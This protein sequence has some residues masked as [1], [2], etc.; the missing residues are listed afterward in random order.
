MLSIF[1]H[2]Y[3]FFGKKMSIQVFC[4]FFKHTILNVYNVN[5]LFFTK[6]QTNQNYNNF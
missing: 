2:L 3:V 5:H 6:F 1:S 4:I